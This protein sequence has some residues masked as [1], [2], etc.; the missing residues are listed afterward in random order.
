[1]HKVLI[2]ED[3][4]L[5]RK[6]LCNLVASEGY[7][8][9]E[10]ANGREAQQQLLNDIELNLLI[11][12][13]NMPEMDGF[14]LIKSIRKNESLYTYIIVLTSIDDR[15]SLLKALSLGADDYLLKPV[16]PEELKLR[17]KGGMR[18][19]E[20][21]G[22]EE[23]IFSMAKLVEYRSEE[24]GF[25]I[26]RTRHYAQLLA[27]DLSENYPELELSPANADLI[28]RVCPL[29]DIGKVAIPD[30]ILHKPGKFSDQ[31]FEIM[32]THTT[33]GGK[34]LKEMFDKTRSP[35]LKYAYEIAM[36]HHERWDG[37]GYP[38]GLSKENIP[39]GARIMALA[40]VYDALTSSRSYKDAYPHDKAKNIILKMKE[41]AFD[42]RLVD[43]FLR[44]E[45]AFI[46]VRERFSN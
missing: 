13:L 34:L 42:P 9:T 8:M 31:E 12:D 27:R 38:Q 28:S 18:I 3:E 6:T 17:L 23:L 35:F 10:A 19:L 5:Q 1:M 11:T 21:E 40:D 25:H 22:L 7:E 45:D 20:L 37:D 4:L 46:A 43:S 16:H 29:H 30:Q 15:A 39:I 14:E 44:Q 33:A 26:E 24:T 2:V 41:R 32:K 36:F